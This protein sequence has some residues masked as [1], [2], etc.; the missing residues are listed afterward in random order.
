[1]ALLAGV[2]VGLV[3]YSYSVKL[4]NMGVLGNFGSGFIG[5]T[6]FLFGVVVV[7]SLSGH[8]LVQIA[9]LPIALFA[10]GILLHDTA[11]NIVGT[12]RDVEGDKAG[13]IRTLPMQ[14]GIRRSVYVA[15][16][17][18]ATYLALFSLPGLLRWNG[19]HLSYLAYV[20]GA[21]LMQGRN[22]VD[23]LRRGDQVGK[24]VA[25]RAHEWYTVERVILG[26]AL[27]AASAPVVALALLLPTVGFT[28]ITQMTMRHR[29]R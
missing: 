13:G 9:P 24:Q 23:L 8:M 16:A 17:F 19:G 21:F 2:V 20:G 4:K 10:T 12:I 11:G 29:Y 22:W 27:V 6:T 15:V 1:V 25:L 5:V 3:A 28:V 18:S 26:L 7:V 14:I